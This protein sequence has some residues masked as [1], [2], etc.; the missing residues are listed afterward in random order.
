MI[1]MKRFSFLLLLVILMISSEAFACSC[2]NFPLTYNFQRSQ[3]VAKAKIIKVT[4]DPSNAE[5]HDAEIE[6]IT[7]YKGE[8]L[9][10][11]K[12]LS[13]MKTSCSFLPATNTTWLIFASMQDGKLSFGN[14]SGSLQTDRT[15]IPPYVTRGPKNYSKSIE[16]KEEILEYLRDRNLN[17][18]PPG[19]TVSNSALE[20]IRGYKSRSTFAVFQ[21]DI[22]AD[23]SIAG[24]KVLKKFQ[25]GALNRA[26]IRAIKTNTIFSAG[27]HKPTKPAQITIFCHF[28]EGTPASKSSVSILDV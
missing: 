26:V 2:I 8:R 3:F 11:I 17:P 23:L 13:M 27:E 1:I 18:N 10:K 24:V 28:Y 16:L 9:T 20:S 14:C 5:Y 15:F 25:N 12:I 19:L 7:V 4:Q 6:L 22:N 21:I